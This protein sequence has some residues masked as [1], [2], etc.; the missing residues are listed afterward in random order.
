MTCRHGCRYNSK[1]S[2]RGTEGE[3]ERENPALTFCH[4]LYNPHFL[5][6]TPPLSTTATTTTAA[7]STSLSNQQFISLKNLQGERST[8]SNLDFSEI[9]LQMRKPNSLTASTAAVAVLIWSLSATVAES[10]IGVNWGTI[11]LHKL[12]PSTVVDLLKANKIEKVKMFDADPDVL[13]GLMGSGIQVMV[14]IPNEMLGVISSSAAASDLWVQKNVSAYMVKG[15]VNIRFNSSPSF[16]LCCSYC[17]LT[18]QLSL[19]LSL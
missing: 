13:K 8:F 1:H 6:L 18:L 14:G 7:N 5:S 2:M 4:L 16:L 17:F 3:R 19:L 15:G 9:Q 12:S 11:S 10:G